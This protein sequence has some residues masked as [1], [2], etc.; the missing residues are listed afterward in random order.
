MLLGGAGHRAAAE[1]IQVNLADHARPTLTGP[2]GGAD[3]I[4]NAWSPV[5]SPLLDS[6]GNPT[7]IRFS[8]AGG[9]P[10]GDWWC[11]L[12]LLTGGVF[13]VGGGTLPVAMEGI[14][15]GWNGPRQLDAGAGAGR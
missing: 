15:P 13:D 6:S 5:A 3:T 10:Y 4:W 2:A 11:D 12:E 14:D 9:G 1:V 8:A 7:T